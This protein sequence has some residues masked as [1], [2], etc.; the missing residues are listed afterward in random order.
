ML[1]RAVT[2]VQKQTFTDWELIVVD[3]SAEQANKDSIR[4]WAEQLQ[5]E[6]KRIIYVDRPAFS[7][8]ED[9]A[10]TPYARVI[11]ETFKLTSGKYITYLCDDDW[12]L[13]GHY[14]CLSQ[15]FEE[16]PEASLVYSGQFILDT[17]DKVIGN[18]PAVLL[19]KCLYFTA[20][21]NCVAH[22]REAY[23][24]VEGW[25]ESKYVRRWGDAEFFYRLAMA[26]Y[27]AYPTGKITVVKTFHPNSVG[28]TGGYQNGAEQQASPSAEDSIDAESGRSD[29]E[30]TDDRAG[31][32]DGSSG[33]GQ[34]SGNPSEQE[35]CRV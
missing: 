7:P 6:D 8:E 27:S 11:N 4:L 34:I 14:Q 35:S 31:G 9:A 17:D 32:G 22:T 20:D 26:K 23:I 13:P 18:L 19:R 3:Y 28:L 29:R 15:V 25:S 1:K 30:L 2:S 24:K 21:H 16:I 12:Y 5:K 10:C 33:I